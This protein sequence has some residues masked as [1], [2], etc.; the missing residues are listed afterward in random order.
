MEV[1]HG[2]SRF[3]SMAND[4][5]AA[6]LRLLA[7][8]T[9]DADQG[10]RLLAL[11]AIY[12]GGSRG[13]AARIGSVGLQTVRDWVLRFNTA[14]PDGLERWQGTGTDAEAQRRPA[15]GACPDCRER[16]DPG[17]P[18]GR[19][20]AAGRDISPSGSG[21]AVGWMVGGVSHLDLEADAKPRATRDGLPQAVRPAPSSCPERIRPA[22]AARADPSS[23][24]DP[25]S[26]TL[27]S[28]D[29]TTGSPSPSRL[30]QP[31][32]DTHNRRNCSVNR[33]R[34]CLKVV[35]RFR[36]GLSDVSAFGTN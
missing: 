21:Y 24:L 22:G 5:D 31:T 29:P 4:F 1:C 28:R 11:A 35:D 34:H 36:G 10:R 19:A 25:S 23:R 16:S 6:A 27:R 8:R 12:G 30:D 13:D 3:S 14:G 32:C 18:R 15:R 20:L 26:R 7:K 33:N 9:R 2:F 17:G